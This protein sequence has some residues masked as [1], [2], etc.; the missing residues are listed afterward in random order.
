[1]YSR[2]DGSSQTFD[3]SGN[4]VKATSADG[5]A[6]ITYTLASGNLSGIATPDGALTT[7]AYVSGKVSTIKT[8]S[9]TVTLTNGSGDLTLIT[10]PDS[11]LHSLAYDASHHVTDDRLAVLRGT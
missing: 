1:T 5:L 6:V 7:L 3:N 8:G 10:N 9:R 4:Q 2:P 11:G